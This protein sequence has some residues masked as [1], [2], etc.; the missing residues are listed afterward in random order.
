VGLFSALKKIAGKV[1]KAGL[2]VATRGVSDKVFSALKSRGQKPATIEAKMPKGRS[3]TEQEYAL[4]NKLGQAAPRVRTTE[5][6]EGVFKRKSAY[7]K[8]R[9]GGMAA[10]PTT[11]TRR[12][13]TTT[14]TTGGKRKPPPGGLDLAA[15][16]REW[17]AAGK[18][19][20]WLS[21][22]KSNQIRRS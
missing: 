19:G 13:K 2:S 11:T 20:T 5:V 12:K 7:K 3:M 4:A 6:Y 18:P 15:M 1:V 16:A 8:K 10:A 9:R 21:W 14:T 17:K 22:I